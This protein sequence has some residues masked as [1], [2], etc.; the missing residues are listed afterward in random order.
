MPSKTKTYN[1]FVI[2]CQMNKSD[3]ERIAGYLEGFGC[4]PVEDVNRADFAIITTC[5]VRQSAE[6]R[7]YGLIPRIKK[8]NPEAK[9][10]LT[11]CLSGRKDVIER[12][13]GRVDVWLP[14]AE[15][16]SLGK[17]LGLEKEKE[18]SSLSGYLGLNPKYD[19]SYSAFVPIG[20]G[21]DNFCAYCV[22]PY[23]R[24]RE[25]WRPAEEIISEV[26]DLAKKGY[27][28]IT[29]IAQNVNSYKSV[30]LIKSKVYQVGSEGGDNF[31]ELLRAVDAIPGDFWLRFAT[32]HP[33]DMSDELIETMAACE[34]LCPHV[35]LP[36]QAGDDGVLGR[37]NRKYTR[38]HYLGLVKKIRNA[39]NP[40]KKDSNTRFLPVAI[41]TDIIV[42]FPGETE[43][44][45]E[46]TAEL[47]REAEFD[48]AYISQYSPR[49]G[50]AA[51]K[52]AD[53]VP[54]AE[55]K[56]REAAL[57]NILSATALANNQAYFG[58][59]VEVLVD[60]EKKGVFY[61]KTKTGKNVQLKIKNYE[62]KI[63][64]G[65]IVKAKISEVGD[66]GMEGEIVGM[67]KK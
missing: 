54:A 46:K 38:E 30:K 29:L 34:K 33:K 24:G 55:K 32:S 20:N 17:K 45:F 11:G 58:R 1:I 37:M 26:D 12:L 19:S 47:F 21:C 40:E 41:S 2:G 18:E 16:E 43:E 31:S 6:D 13:S 49:F 53:D 63:K 14:I 56:R 4:A 9:I 39:F 36:A 27:K 51:A 66:F 42:G 5:G 52:L 3:S 25:T 57:D 35:H 10:I 64:E 60:T 22:V 15:L 44:Q 65:C 61:G 7:V 50:T 67:F 59:I 23:A 8:N 28:E 62:F 48:M